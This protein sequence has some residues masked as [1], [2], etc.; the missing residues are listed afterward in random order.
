MPEPKY[1]RVEEIQE[2]PY[3]IHYGKTNEISVD[4]LVLGG[5]L[6]GG[7]AA[8]AAAKKGVKVAVVEKAGMQ[9]SGHA[10]GGLDHWQDIYIPGVS[11]VTAEQIAKARNN[12]LGGY[13]REELF[14][15]GAREGWERLLDLEK[16]GIKIRDT[17]DKYSGS[18]HRD[19]KSKLLFAHDPRANTTVIFWGA[20]QFGKPR[21][22][23]KWAL[24]N[25]SKR[26][27]VDVF[28]RTMATSLLTE[29]GKQGARVVGV[30]ALNIRTGEFYIFKAKAVVLT[31]GWVSRLWFYAGNQ[32]RG[33]WGYEGAG[34][35]NTGDGLAMAVRAGAE[36]I[37]MESSHP[38]RAAFGSSNQPIA[39]GAGIDDK[40]GDSLW[41]IMVVDAQGKP[42][43]T[44][45]NRNAHG[46]GIGNVPFFIAPGGTDKWDG[47]RLRELIKEGIVPPPLYLD[48]SS[49]REQ[50]KKVVKEVNQ[51]NE[52]G[53]LGQMWLGQ[54]AGE[55]WKEE[56]TEY[57][58]PYIQRY[59]RE[60]KPGGGGGGILI[61]A[62]AETTLE[63]LFAGGDHTP[64]S[65]NASGAAVFGWK[66]GTNAADYA[67]K[68]AE[69]RVNKKQVNDE[70]TRVYFP[71][72]RNDGISW[73]ELTLDTK[74]TMTCY[75]NEIKNEWLFQKGL[76]TFHEIKQSEVPK[77]YARN[78]HE[79]MHAL[80]TLSI[81]T[82]GEMILHSSLVRKASSRSL[83]FFRQDYP[84]MDPPEWC[85]W[86]TVKMEDGK[87]KTGT[88]PIGR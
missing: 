47:E 29:G 88:R 64:G 67:R 23:I 3:P 10:G 4:V 5:G 57:Q 45:T 84:E 30:T 38:S 18:I 77:L 13:G 14:C 19:E 15:M 26:L 60:L 40:R 1:V 66:A 28:N 11:T 20:G 76:E 81:I 86:V 39:G 27:G 70:K 80:E 61:N 8:I 24:Y 54:K 36:L 44:V 83:G 75:C 58:R 7:F 68:A 56:M 52:G 41:P 25:E 79:L 42:V 69:P 48:Q 32:W 21:G 31:T 55:E 74:Y 71:I 51:G 6:A 2:W 37:N 59:G 43:P 85:K 87:V 82:V 17:E 73:R 50:D 49:L 9:R 72:E 33:N 53:W 63:G 16:L 22:G 62:N 46:V 65:V 34:A 35:A 12:N 78:P